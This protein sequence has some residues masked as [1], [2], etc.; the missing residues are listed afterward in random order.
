MR[1]L[2]RR[3][4]DWV[5]HRTGFETAVK[6]F[7]YEDIPASSGWH[8]VFGSVALFL[9]F[10]QAFTGV[11]LAFNYAPQPGDAYHSLQYIVNEI[12][13]GRLIR[14]LH[15]WGS[16]LMVVV[17]GLHMVQVALWGAYKKPRE[18]TW[19]LGVL[20]LLL[21]LAFGLTGYLLPWDNRAY[22]AT[23]VTIEIAGLAP[24]VGEYMLEF[25]GGTEGV[26]VSTFTRFYT[27]HV[28]MLPALTVLLMMLH[29]H[30]VR[31][32]GVTPSPRAIG[33]PKKKFY[34]GQAFKDLMAFFAVFIL[35]FVLA[36]TVDVP[37]ERLADPSDSTYV[38]R[39]EW[40]FLFLFQMLKFFEGRWEVVGAVILPTLAVLAL[41]VV[42]FLDRA[43]VKRI[44]QR[45]LAFAVVG[46]VLAGWLALT[47]AAD[48]TTPEPVESARETSPASAD[49]RLLTPVELAGR[50]YF[51]REKCA[52]CH[53]LS[54][55]EP[56]M[57]PTLA[58]VSLRKPTE[59]LMGHFGNPSEAVPGSPMPATT[60]SDEESNGLAAFVLKLTPTNAAALE[61]VPAYAMRAAVIYQESQCG[62]CHVVNG[63]GEESGPPLNGV[64]QRRTAEWLEDHFRDPQKFDPQ[65]VMPPYDF[66]P[67]DMK[68]IVAYMQAL[69]PDPRH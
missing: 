32:H 62:A 65:S 34:P 13:G 50:A 20:L 18:A 43:K 19:I 4:L 36:A 33:Q 25:L 9:F 8:Q 28:L 31:K 42:P 57:G 38:P 29:I 68:A 44:Q 52:G 60:I 30:L 37:L 48:L 24:L 27:L 67:E 39:P 47:V 6:N 1:D 5:D 10:V 26:G 46:V 17:V 54:E 3:I 55:G 59:W 56:K 35:L 61:A 23:V 64:G 63:S 7:L 51:Q 12:T 14:G 15:H 58:T 40:Y 21:V 53:N 41:L 45:T 16:S 11:L 66:P 69:P 2:I 22:W 49:W